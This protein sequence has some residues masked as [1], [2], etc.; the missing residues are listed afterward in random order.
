MTK[1]FQKFL[2]YCVSFALISS[3][4]SAQLI[5]ASGTNQVPNAK[6]M[7]AIKRFI[8]DKR[9]VTM[10]EIGGDLSLSGDVRTLFAFQSQIKNGKQ[11]FG[12]DGLDYPMFGWQTEFNMMLDYRT[13][14][15]WAA[16][17]LEFDNRMGQKSG[18]MNSIR[19]EKAY[20]GGRLVEGDTFT[21]D[22]EVGRR[23][24]VAVFDS[25]LQFGSLYDGLNFRFAKAF[26]SIAECYSNIGAF[27]INFKT[28]HY[29]L[30]GEIGALSIA[31]TGLN[32]KYS[33]IDWYKPGGE[34]VSGKTA[35]DNALENLNY[36]YLVSQ[37]SGSYQ[38]NPEWFWKKLIKFY[39]AGLVNHL[40]LDNPLALAGVEGQAFG[41]QNWGF[42]AGISAGMI[43]KMHD[44]AI[45]FN[46]QW[47]QAQAVPDSIGIGRGNVG[48]LYF[49]TVDKVITPTSLATAEGRGNFYGF[50]LNGSYAISNNLLINPVYYQSWTLDKNIGPNLRYNQF[51]LEFVYAF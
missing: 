13:E 42:Y 11:T 15:T 36:R 19:L 41:K 21:F 4:A 22:A 26:E 50:A 37:F 33:V 2:S 31:D 18:T 47:L 16:M 20:V 24:L 46:F 40:A 49:N 34:G 29:G 9:M 38:F 43:K 32:L 23:T 45:D 39:G 5:D 35:A 17:K 27:I 7:D 12:S 44:W 14:R 8:S 10:K 1:R 28:N 51:R 25:R 3:T 6:D 48:G 30:V